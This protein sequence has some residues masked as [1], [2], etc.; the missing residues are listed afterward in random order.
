MYYE[1]ER[2][3]QHLVDTVV[4]REKTLR[5]E[6]AGQ[7]LA[8]LCA[9]DTALTAVCKLSETGFTDDWAAGITRLATIAADALIAE[10][11]RTRDEE[12]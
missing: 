8:G 9:N 1:S 4:P 2:Q 11:E 7:A 10:L 12:Q 3:L 6:Y 5:E